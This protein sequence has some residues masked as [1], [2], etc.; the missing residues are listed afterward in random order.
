MRPERGFSWCAVARMGACLLAAT[1]ALPAL[2]GAGGTFN[3][4][5]F[6]SGSSAK[7]EQMIGDHD[8]ADTTRAVT[9]LTV[10]RADVLGND[11][12]TSMVSG[13]SLIFL[14]GDTI[15][16][17]QQYV[18]RWAQ[19]L[20]PYRWTAHEPIASSTSSD[21]EGGVRLDFY[22][23]AA[24]DS[25][26]IV[27]PVYPDSA[28]LDMG[29]DRVPHAGVDLDGKL[30]IT[31]KVGTVIVNG[32]AVSDS[33]SSV[34]VRFHPRLRTFTA[35]RTMSR[36]QD[37]GEFVTDAM[38]ELPVQFA[39]SPTD[40]EVVIFGL[41]RYAQSDVYLSMIP[42]ADFASGV[43]A[44]GNPAT[45]YFTG[46]VNG[47]PTWSSLET[48]S[49]PVVRDDPLSDIGIGVVQ[50]P[51]PNDSPTIAHVSIAWSSELNLW[52]MLYDGGRQQAP[53]R[54]QTEGVWFS[55]AEAPWG[56]WL[57]PQLIYNATR[58]GGF[59]TFIHQYDHSTDVGTGPAGPTIGDQSS[60]DPDTTSGS[61]YAPGIIEPFVRVA[62]DTLKLYYSMATWNPY[63]NVLMRSEFLI[64]P[65]TLGVANGPTLASLAAWP[66]PFR[67]T[68]RVRFDMPRLGPVSVEVYDVAGQRVRDLL[69]TTLPPGEHTLSWDGRTDAGRPAG[70]GLYFIRVRAPGRT[71]TLRLARVGS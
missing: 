20:D 56:P 40:S 53:F 31:C 19:I 55:Y 46:I 39:G 30:W 32:V 27:Q 3:Q 69:A 11:V 57:T 71:A 29:A 16:A 22:T 48:S 51:W 23:N 62:G 65:G 60:N 7:V 1:V 25:T 24:G 28:Q 21:P 42:K 14:F 43:D 10:T 4:L 67:A 37:G 5:T 34:V 26:L 44:H 66:N 38:R 18:P 63:T 64:T 15:G 58:D 54:K 6:V 13:D 49:V 17:S 50:Q 47:Q 8:W 70:E 9:S 52:L 12:C 59:G 36:I 45:R 68:T 61:V 2:A 35:G 33:D 41:G